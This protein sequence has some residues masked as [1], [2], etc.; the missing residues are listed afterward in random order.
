MSG[1][2][3][4]EVGLG[5]KEGVRVVML[6]RGGG[7]MD[8]VWSLGEEEE[9]CLWVWEGRRWEEVVMVGGGERGGSLSVGMG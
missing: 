1:C 7:G 2:G 5:S 3:D 6:G 8:L 4:K 9:V